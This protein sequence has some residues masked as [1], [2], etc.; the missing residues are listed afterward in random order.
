VQVRKE[1]GF[2]I[3]T[4][5]PSCRQSG[6]ALAA[7]SPS[8]KSAF[9]NLLTDHMHF[10]MCLQV[11]LSTDWRRQAHLKQQL[12]EVLARMNIDCIGATPMRAMFHPVRPLEITA[13]LA[14][15]T[16][17]ITD[18]V[19]IDDRD[20]LH[21]NGGAALQGHFV[22]THP[23]SGLTS[24]LADKAIKILQ[25]G[26]PPSSP[27]ARSPSSAGTYDLSS[28]RS[29]LPSPATQSP[30]LSP[31]SGLHRPPPGSAS[32]SPGRSSAFSIDSGCAANMHGG[33]ISS[34][35]SSYTSPS[36]PGFGARLDTYG[37]VPESFA[38][39]HSMHDS[40]R[41]A[42]R[43]PTRSSRP[44]TPGSIFANRR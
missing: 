27:Q 5:S 20:L 32:L 37:K 19:A 11:V 38:T 6:D 1:E 40:Q 13:W 14:R 8:S 10:P 23:A 2:G 16:H 35:H 21:E 15:S 44:N 28:L 4:S 34:P 9:A 43:T 22:R 7:F 42:L 25:R 39:R 36:T 18:W 30:S 31:P 17:S 29:T 3:C 41:Y 12:R 26:G 24:A 33:A